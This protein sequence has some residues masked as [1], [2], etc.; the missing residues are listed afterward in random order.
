MKIKSNIPVFLIIVLAIMIIFE[1]LF[2]FYRDRLDISAD[3]NKIILWILFIATIITI[4]LISYILFDIIMFKKQFEKIFRRLLNGDF[5]VGLVHSRYSEFLGLRES[6][7]KFLNRLREYDKL[8]ADKV[9]YYN[10]IF[11]VIFRNADEGLMLMD[12]VRRLINLNPACQKI[13]NISQD[14]FKVDAIINIPENKAFRS[15]LKYVQINKAIKKIKCEFCLP[16]EKS[17]TRV[18]LKFIPFRNVKENVPV[19]LIKVSALKT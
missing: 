3:I 11:K 12:N 8:R 7:N 17:K 14:E 10:K 1:I 4:I 6:I 19:Y 5:E 18:Y 13:F 9:V 15:A 16:V 2:L